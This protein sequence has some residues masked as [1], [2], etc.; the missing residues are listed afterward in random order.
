MKSMPSGAGGVLSGSEGAVGAALSGGPGCADAQAERRRLS[1][2][3]YCSRRGAFMAIR[4]PEIWLWHNHYSGNPNQR[5]RKLT[6]RVSWVIKEGKRCPDADKSKP[7]PVRECWSP[8]FFP[9]PLLGK[10]SARPASIQP[11]E[12]QWRAA[13]VTE[14]AVWRQASPT[15]YLHLPPGSL[16]DK[17][18]FSA[19]IT[20]TLAGAE[21]LDESTL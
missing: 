18:G 11:E 13:G 12:I 19:F 1:I 8:V 3:K 2:S 9:P 5:A 15:A 16:K 21:T 17:F 4:Q 7:C 6:G 10:R 14:L 20:D